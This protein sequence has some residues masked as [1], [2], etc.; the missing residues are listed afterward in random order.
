MHMRGSLA[1]RKRTEVKEILH[2]PKYV[3]I[4]CVYVHTRVYVCVQL[5]KKPT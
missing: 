1:L 3:K 2:R 5:K 4:S